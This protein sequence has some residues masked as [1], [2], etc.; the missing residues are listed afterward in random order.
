[1]SGVR[2]VVLALALAGAA[3]ACRGGSEPS[4][5]GGGQARA[6]GSGGSAAGSSRGGSAPAG[7]APARADGSAEDANGASTERAGG[8]AGATGSSDDRAGSAGGAAQ[9]GD[10]PAGSSAGARAAAD[11][12]PSSAASGAAGAA[13]GAPAS[14]S[15]ARVERVLWRA[16]DNR[17]MAHRTVGQDVVVDAGSYAF[18]RYIHFGIPVMRWRLAQQVGGEPAA[19]ASPLAA[20][21]IPLSAEQARAASVLALRVHASEPLALTVKLNGRKPRKKAIELVAGWQN[22]AQEI[23]PGWF[24]PGENQVVLEHGRR[25]GTVALAWARAGERRELPSPLSSARFVDRRL[26]LHAG[27]SVAWYVTLPEGGHLRA[28]VAAP[29]QV[30]VRAS[31]T[32]GGFVGG[33]LSAEREDGRVDLSSF[34][35]KVVRLELSADSPDPDDGLDGSTPAAPPARCEVARIEEPVI[36]VHGPEAPPPPAGK[37]PRYVILWVLDST[38]ADRMPIFTPGAPVQTPNLEELARTSA[39]FRQYYTQ[40]NESQTSHSTVWSGV[41]PAV[42]NVRLAGNNGNTKLPARL[43]VIAEL[44]A[45]AGLR[46]IAVTGNGF[47]TDSGG[48]TRGFQE[49]RNMMREKGVV[50]GVL[51]GEQIVAAAMGRLDANRADPTYLFFG[52]VDSHS[53]W[54]ARQ[55]WIDRYWADDY[56]GPFRTYGEPGALGMRRGK[57]G[58]SKVPPLE[59][60]ERLR[61]IYDSTISYSDDLIG[62]V[63]AQ[64]KIWNIWDQTMLILTADHGDELF[65]HKRCGHGGSLRDTLVRVPLLIHYPAQFQPGFF[66]EGA[67]GVDILPTILD[68]LGAPPLT[69][70]QGHSLRPLTAGAGRGWTS[71]SYAS[72][73]EY[74]HAMRL[75]RWK[76]AVNIRG[77]VLV[78][79]MRE[80]PLEKENRAGSH[81]VETRMLADHLGLFV[82]TRARWQKASWGV[83]SSITAEGA[84]VLD[85]PVP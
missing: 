57:M 54:I 4:G 72:Q 25:K 73:Y 7:A 14:G 52:T 58:C 46:P 81:P 38:R 84:K 60:V 33:R 13:P 66:D 15:G 68:A 37:P 32:D 27:S 64:L 23:P 21:E 10:A 53:P 12:S 9:S 82:A 75:G 69:T 44:V 62:K 70:S 20:L 16:V 18:A 65:E 11:G 61:A 67:E 8:G 83:V 5:D 22:L 51:Y 19:I 41:Y 2:R 39:V 71:P 55:P 17:V 77:E 34:S 79:D 28:R 42:H 50:N 74:A 78:L 49:F 3:A 76:M 47:V 24:L 56:N 31:T 30:S 36:T 40:G 29:C 45:K 59:D 43:P 35:G 26:E 1:V 80:D 6:A 85:G 48:Y 63:I